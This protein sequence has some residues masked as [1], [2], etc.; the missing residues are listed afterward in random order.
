ME[1]LTVEEARHRHDKDVVQPYKANSARSYVG[2]SISDR[3]AL[4]AE[5][6]KDPVLFW[7]KIAADNFYWKNLWPSEKP[8]MEFNFHKSKGKV[9]VKWFDGARTNICYNALDRHL[10]QHKDRVCYYW[11]GNAEGET[12]SVTYGNMH[13][14]VLQLAA[15]LRHQYGVRKG[16]VVTLYL[17]MIPFT[18]QL[19]LAVA[20]IGAV[21]SVVFAGFSGKALASRIIDSA[22]ELVITADSSFRGEKPIPLKEVVDVAIAECESE[23]HHIQC[24][25]YERHGRENI[26]MKSGRDRWYGDVVAAMTASQLAD[27]PIEWVGAEDPLFMLYTSGSTGKPKAILHTVGGYMVFAGTTFKY[28]FDYHEDDVYFCTADIGWVTGH[29]YV[30]YGP[31]LNAATSVLFEGTPT[32]PTPSRWWELVDKYGVTVFYTAPTAIRSLMQY[33][34][35]PVKRTSRATLRVL[36]SVGEPINVEAW[37]WYYGVVGEGHVDISDT[38]WQTETGGH[39][40]T[41]LPGCTPLK[42]GSATL[43]FFGI[44]PALLDPITNAEIDGPGEGLLVIKSPWPGQARTIFGDSERYEQMYFSVDGYYMTGD[45]ARRDEDGY[46]WITGRVDDVLNVSGHR[47]GTSEVE[48]A[49]NTHPLVVESA[50]VGIP[51]DTKGEGIYVYVTFHQNTIIDKDLLNAVRATVRKVIGPLATPDHIHPAQCGLP[52]TRSGKILRRILRK[53]AAGIFDGLG[54]ISTLAD[55]TIVAKLIEGRNGVSI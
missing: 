28:S 33:D 47:I 55:Q 35:E 8:A 10:T 11:E 36:G 9:F 26:P 24:L 53:I 42:P 22:S 23:G 49:V 27:C 37:R 21:V 25:V 17:P 12:S 45:G 5:S 6:K 16:Q 44:E 48:D 39:L 31:M 34:D 3:Q 29:S 4:Y 43:P 1:N 46:Y 2:K 41:P 54:D 32:Y 51:H 38:W 52:K 15:V 20:R 40:I 18:V 50:V 7:S 14:A 19:M 30:V 13:E